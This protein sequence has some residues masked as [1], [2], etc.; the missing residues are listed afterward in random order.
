MNFEM[1]LGKDIVELEI[2]DERVFGV[3]DG[4]DIEPL[5]IE[6]LKNV[7]S[8]GIKKTTP[9][10]IKEK[11]VAI[12][13]PDHTRLWAR[14]D[15]LVP[16]IVDALLELGA[17]KDNIVVIIALGTHGDAPDEMFPSL[18]GEGTS[19]RVRVLNSANKNYD[20]LT[21]VGKTSFGTELYITKEACEADHIIL[22][23]GL[24][25]H[26]IAGFGGGRKYILPG[27]A[28]YDTIQQNHS[29]ALLKDGSPHPNVYQGNLEENPVHMDMTEA[30]S[31]FLA[32]KTS[33][34][35]A[36]AANGR[37]DIFHAE[38][39]D[40]KEVFEKGCLEVNR[41]G[42]VEISEP[43]DFAI[44]SAG[45]HRKDGQLYQSTKALFNTYN[46]L[47]EG[48][49]ILFFA[50]SREGVGSDMFEDILIKYKGNP[51]AIGK[52]LVEDFN[53][54][55]YVAYR[56][57]DILTRFEVTLVSS[58]SKEKTEKLGFLYTNDA[59]SYVSNLEGR[60]LIIPSAENILPVITDKA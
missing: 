6:K 55:V 34:L 11:K 53:M 60:G 25:H 50:E 16:V 13:V 12:V 22:F 43:A 10:D 28:G 24:L 42:C 7:V 39:G 14:G 9:S 33:C 20:R 58:F 46:V 5:D 57:V 37:G 15:L 49:K 23:G 41:A 4:P 51:S 19:S 59:A 21:L 54:G 8:T 44:I 3:L 31:M 52:K 48:G 30:A 36:V 47:K 26:L 32:D 27:I 1:E 29:L 17:R 35:A 2:S 18:V 56:V 40:W 38:V 45:G